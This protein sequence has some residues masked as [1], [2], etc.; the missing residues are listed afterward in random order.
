MLAVNILLSNAFGCCTITQLDKTYRSMCANIP[1]RSHM[2]L[3][4]HYSPPTT[5]Y[6][7]QKYFFVIKTYFS[8]YFCILS[9]FLEFP[10][11]ITFVLFISSKFS[12]F[13]IFSGF[14]NVWPSSISV[15][16]KMNLLFYWL[17]V[18]CDPQ[19][20]LPK[21]SSCF[22]H[23]YCNTFPTSKRTYMHM[24]SLY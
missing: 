17:N 11:T 12:D 19:K 7:L 23:V 8:V 2:P 13:M 15:L 4:C 24:Y 14:T 22:P 3:L 5:Y 20:S 10:V 18:S 9:P 6:Y 1:I 16:H 21:I